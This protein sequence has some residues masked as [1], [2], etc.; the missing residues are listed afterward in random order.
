MVVYMI[1]RT[2][3]RP[4]GVFR[5]MRAIPGGSPRL[6]LTSDP[7]LSVVIHLK[8]VVGHISR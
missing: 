3:I 1:D 4:T 5:V 8:P 2:G 7:K 6:D